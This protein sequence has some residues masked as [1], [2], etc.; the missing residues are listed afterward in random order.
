MFENDVK[1]DTINQSINQSARQR[2]ILPHDVVGYLTKWIFM[3][4]QSCDIWL[5]MTHHGNA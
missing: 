5:V 2:T 3:D 1:H 4:P